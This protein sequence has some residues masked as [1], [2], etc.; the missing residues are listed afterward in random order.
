[1]TARPVNSFAQLAFGLFLL[2]LASLF[3]A[4]EA[5]ALSPAD[6]VVVFNLNLPESRAV[7]NYYAKKRKVPLANLLGVDLPTSENMARSDFDKK[8]IPPVRAR[9]GRLRDKGKTP[10]ILLVYG[11]PLTVGISPPVKPDAAFKALAEGKIKEYLGLVLQM[12]RELNDLTGEH[13]SPPAPPKD[14]S[15]SPSL[16]EA[17]KMV[18]ESLVQGQKYLEK[19]QAQEGTR[20][21]RA[22]VFSLMVRLVGTS[23]ATQALLRQMAQGDPKERHQFQGQ[24]LLWGHLILVR[25]LIEAYFWGLPPEKALETASSARFTRGLLGEL[26][27]WEEFKT[28]IIGSKTSAAVDSE[29]ALSLVDH[30]QQGYWLPNPFQARYDHTPFINEI[31]Q[32]TLMVGRLDGPTPE[33]AKRLVDD[34]VATEE[35]G[36]TGIF[37]IDAR[38]I[39][40]K[41]SSYG[42]Y[43]WYDQ[44]LLDLY[45]LVKNHS[46]MKVVIDTDPGLFP[47]GACPHAALYCGWYSLAHYIDSFGWQKGA[48][49]YHVASSEARTL[50][51][52]DSNVWCKRMLEKGVAATLGPVTEPYLSSFPLPDQFFPLL[53]SGQMPLLEV[54]FRTLP[55]VA[56]R[57]ILI[58][59][60][61]YTPFKKNPAIRLPIE[62][63]TDA[64]K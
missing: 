61:L 6:L 27:F 62:R 47:P 51:N 15:K 43:A 55:Q 53:M 33:I 18:E 26:K 54:Y 46:S 3:T 57:Q 12:V 17:L 29:L 1:M 23:P 4:V 10:A 50:K 30:Y 63:G 58:G 19:S 48:V 7:A 42:S 45:D 25:E 39:A 24:E 38:G 56:W 14:L 11:I 31:R 8:L 60:P 5:L 44:H 28:L 64:P 2:L 41:Q 59:D 20:A 9:V 21:T 34:A 36:L 37:Y 40:N 22:K 13:D 49:G 32:K 35:T 52:P 16:V